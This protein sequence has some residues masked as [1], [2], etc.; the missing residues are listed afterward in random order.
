MLRFA[1]HET[2]SRYRRPTAELEQMNRSYQKFDEEMNTERTN[3]V[4]KGVGWARFPGCCLVDVG[5]MSCIIIM[6]GQDREYVRCEIRTSTGH[7]LFTF[8]SI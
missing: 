5:G 4:K 3:E 7:R 6:W 2:W 8:R 1:E